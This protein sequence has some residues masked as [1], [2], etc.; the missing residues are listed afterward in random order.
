MKELLICERKDCHTLQTLW[1]A[2][3]FTSSKPSKASKQHFIM[4]ILKWSTSFLRAVPYFPPCHP[5]YVALSI[6]SHLYLQRGAQKTLHHMIKTDRPTA[7]KLARGLK[8]L[9]NQ[10]QNVHIW[11][12]DVTDMWDESV[13]RTLRGTLGRGHGGKLGQR[14]QRGC[15]VLSS[16]STHR[17]MI[18]LCGYWHV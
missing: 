8:T 4:L 7:F 13:G 6:S 10:K 15:V 14:G 3:H 18:L 11:A 17:E 1:H 2:I 9:S 5:L 12:G 16:L